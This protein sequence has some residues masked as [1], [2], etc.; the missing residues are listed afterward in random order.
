MPRETDQANLFLS[1]EADN[2]FRRN[3]SHLSPDQANATDWPL[4]L[5]RQSGARPR[6]ALEIGASNG[7]RLE[8]LRRE[9]GCEAEGVEPS[10][11]AAAHAA[12][13]F[14]AVRLHQGV[15]HDLGRWA[16][17]HFDLVLLCLMLH[18][19]DRH[20]LLKT[21]AEVD[22][23]L[24][25][26]GHLLVSDFL[27]ESPHKVRYHHR[28]EVEAWTY[29]QNYPALWLASGLYRP[30]KEVTFDHSTQQ[31][32]EGIDPSHRCHAV[33]MKKM[34]AANYPPRERP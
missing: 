23:V 20:R 19:V 3:L 8:C 15:S 6:R 22:R 24:A 32:G 12:A 10:S 1:G 30:V 26:G 5:L 7:Y 4:Q 27:P 14:P 16:D 18:W 28:P 31:A 13:E 21:V 34:G 33:L 9:L 11:A 29:K 17:G 25:D 2:W